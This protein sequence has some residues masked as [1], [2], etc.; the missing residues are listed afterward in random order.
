MTRGPARETMQD[1]RSSFSAGH[2]LLRAWWGLVWLLLFRPSPRPLHRW[3]AFLLRV[4]GADVHP[5]AHVYPRA[6][7]WF[8]PNLTL[9]RH[10]CIADDGTGIRSICVG[11]RAQQWIELV[12]IIVG[13]VGVVASEGGVVIQCSITFII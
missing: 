4:H 9:E 13:G 2:R 7:V 12:R 6:R 11:V 10:A 3:R 8:P 5:T 1:T